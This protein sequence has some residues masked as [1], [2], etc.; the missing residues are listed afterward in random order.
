M[1]D[2]ELTTYIS[3]Y[4]WVDIPWND[5]KFYNRPLICIEDNNDIVSQPFSEDFIRTWIHC[6]DM[7]LVAKYIHWYSLD[8]LNELMYKHRINLLDLVLSK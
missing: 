8:F 2:Q 5:I 3:K 4:P 7:K 6:V 1:S